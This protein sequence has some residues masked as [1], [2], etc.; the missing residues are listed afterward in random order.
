MLGHNKQRFTSLSRRLIAFIGVIVPRRFRTRWRRE[1]EAELEYREE[2]LARWDR[3]NWHNKL[4]LLW[5]S[6]GAFWDALWLQRQRWEDEMIQDLRYGARMLLKKPGFT[7]IAIITLALGIGANTALFSVVNAV[8]LRP[9]PY[10]QPD[11]LVILWERTP[12]G[13][14]SVAY[15]NFVDWRERNQVFEQITAFRRDSFNLTGAG[16][17]ERLN[18]RMVSAGFFAT[19]GKQPPRGRDF[20]AADDQPGAA[21]AVILS[22]DFWQRRFGGDG[23]IVGSQLT[24]SNRVFTVIGIAASDF[25]FGAGADVFVPL[26]LHADRFRERGEHPGIYVVGRLKPGVNMEQARAGMDTIMAALGEQ[27]PDTN[28]DRRAHLESLYDNTVQDVRPALFILLGAVGF[29]LLIACANVANLLLSAA[30]A[31][32]KEIAL[33]AALGAGRRR[34][35]RQLLTES[36]LLSLCGGLL[37]ALLAI[38]GTEALIAFV[39]EGIPRLEEAEVDLRA[40]GF[41][42]LLAALTSLIFGLAPALQATRFDL[43]EVLKEGE[44]GSTGRRSRV[45]N[46]LVVSEVALAL[47]LLIG[48]G[49]MIRSFRQLRQVETGFE[50]TNLLTMN[51]SLTVTPDEAAKAH[52]FL[53][54][55]GQKLR[56]LPGVQTAAISSGMPFAATTEDS[57]YLAGDDPNDPRAE[58]VAV[59]YLTSPEYLQTLGIRLLR[60]RYFTPRDRAGSTPVVVIDETLARKH[61]P[62]QNPIGKRLDGLVIEQP[63]IIGVV[64]QVK[65]YGLEGRAPVEHQLYLPLAQIP[66]QSLPS[67]ARRINVLL[68]TAGDPLGVAAAARGEAQALNANQ[69][70]FNVRTME[71]LVADSIAGQRFSLVLLALFAGL[72]L[73][74]AAVGIYGVMSSVVE[75][76]RREIGIRLALGA[77]RR[78][79]L[80]LIAKQGLAMAVIG[81]AVGLIASLALTRLMAT[82]LFGV[83]ATDPLT[84]AGVAALLIAVAA[85]ACYVPA[86]RAMKTDPLVALRYE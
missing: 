81:V 59:V 40:L 51:L 27:F 9:L 35:V 12:M 32:R 57:F 33:R 71:R 85:L 2:L 68:R 22:H 70:V 21:A 4:E 8:L 10:Q 50:A 74:L 11:R 38:W 54:Q 67:V 45:R 1:W 63:E 17:T 84:F 77:Q 78:D 14:A 37:G 80:R 65:H 56:Q 64:G 20:T 16:E 83:S 73:A 23:K 69:P 41:T 39:P 26:G 3:L 61:F 53:D 82:L 48:A 58:K 72:A 52:N 30:A 29:V 15:P 43:D 31:R 49:L 28:K 75:Q 79:V 25:R 34:V 60:G 76:R 36:V 86:R 46:L 5:R 7:L 66:P 55:L 6:S 13:E 18:G 24:L 19:F 62:D 47:V 44:R 42:L